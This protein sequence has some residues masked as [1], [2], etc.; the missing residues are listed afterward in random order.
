MGVFGED[1][2][3]SSKSAEVASLFGEDPNQMPSS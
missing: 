1:F 3:E 2:Y